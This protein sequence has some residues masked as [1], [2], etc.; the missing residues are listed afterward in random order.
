M[1]RT[2]RKKAVKKITTSYVVKNGKAKRV[3]K[4]TPINKKSKKSKGKR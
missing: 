1:A 2:A 3:K 4:Y